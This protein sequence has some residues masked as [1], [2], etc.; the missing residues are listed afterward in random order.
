M[1]APQMATL[2]HPFENIRP[3]SWAD[4]VQVKLKLRI[5]N[6]QKHFSWN[7][8]SQPFNETITFLFIGTSIFITNNARKWNYGFQ[9]SLGQSI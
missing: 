9:V 4:E 3:L 5:R 7:L 6:K 1:S 8:L 2:P